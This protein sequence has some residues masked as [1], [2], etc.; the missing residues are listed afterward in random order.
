MEIL[1]HFEDITLRLAPSR[2]SE[3]SKASC[4]RLEAKSFQEMTF[5]VIKPGKQW[6]RSPLAD[7]LQTGN[8]EF[9]TIRLHMKS[10]KMKLNKGT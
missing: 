6:F 4:N 9:Q 8:Y 7:S 10:L 5:K 2:Y 3:F 1:V